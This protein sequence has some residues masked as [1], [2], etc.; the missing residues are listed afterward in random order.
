VCVRVTLLGTTLA[1]SSPPAPIGTAVRKWRWLVV[2]LPELGEISCRQGT[3]LC[4]RCFVVLLVH[5]LVYGG[6]A[7]LSCYTNPTM[8]HLLH[9]TLFIVTLCDAVHGPQQNPQRISHCTSYSPYVVVPARRGCCV[10]G[11]AFSAFRHAGQDGCSPQNRVR[12]PLWCIPPPLLFY[13]PALLPV[14]PSQCTT[15]TDTCLKFVTLLV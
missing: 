13:F 11:A 10:V 5:V 9:T 3:E 2:I 14:E 6:G 1:G 8:T 12:F 15:V 7:P 4:G